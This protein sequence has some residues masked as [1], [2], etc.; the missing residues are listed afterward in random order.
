[1]KVSFETKHHETKADAAGDADLSL[2]LF[3]CNC[4][5]SFFPLFFL[6]KKEKNGL[7][8]KKG[9]KILA[10]PAAEEDK[11]TCPC[12]SKAPRV[13][14]PPFLTLFFCRLIPIGSAQLGVSRLFLLRKK[15]ENK[16]RRPTG[17][18]CPRGPGFF[19]SGA[20]QAIALGTFAPPQKA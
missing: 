3:F 10:G 5:V 9:D 13:A 19:F 20:G 18:Y 15:K 2:F 1:M 6:A 16:M 8:Q 12:E 7:K 17:R 11:G 14:E 4:S